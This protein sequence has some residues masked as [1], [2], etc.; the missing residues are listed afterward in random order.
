MSAILH[1]SL[2]TIIALTAVAELSLTAFLLSKRSDTQPF[3]T[4]KFH[5]L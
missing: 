2:F 5:D 3:E 4:Q 1:Q